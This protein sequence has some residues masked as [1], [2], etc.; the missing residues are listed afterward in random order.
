MAR[1]FH[2][3]AGPRPDPAPAPGLPLNGRRALRGGGGPVTRPRPL[4]GPH[5]LGPTPGLAAEAALGPFG[6]LAGGGGAGIPGHRTQDCWRQVPRALRGQ[7]R[8]ASRV[9]GAPGPTFDRRWRRTCAGGPCA[10]EIPVL[11]GSVLGALCCRCLCKGALLGGSTRGLCWAS[12]G[13]LCVGG[14]VLG[15]LCA[16]ELWTLLGTRVGSSVLGTLCWGVCTGGSVL[17]GFVLGGLCWA[18]G[19][20]CWASVLGVFTGL[21]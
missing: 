6:K 2:T 12:A 10:G 20:L 3:T 21:L 13:E 18:S 19:T 8:C 9:L 5:G 15:G 16:G 7:P 17:G 4:K 1:R 14:S 11:R